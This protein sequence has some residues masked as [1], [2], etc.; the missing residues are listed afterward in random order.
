MG[1]T[2]R[3]LLDDV[4]AT[5]DQIVATLSVSSR[6]HVSSLTLRG[7]RMVLDGTD[8]GDGR[9]AFTLAHLSWRQQVEAP[10]AGGYRL[11]ATDE[12]GTNVPVCP[13][14]R[15]SRMTPV[16][17]LTYRAA[18][19]FEH[20]PDGQAYV[21]VSAPLC[22]DEQGRFH[23][24]RLA[25]EFTGD[26]AKS[27]SGEPEGVFLESWYGKTFS[28]NPAPLVEALRAVGVPGPYR[29]AVADRSVEHPA[30]VEA[31]IT[32]STDYWR[33]LGSSRV[34][35]FNTWLPSEFKKGRGQ[36]IVQTWHGT[37]L[38]SLGMDVPERIGS[39]RAAKNLRRGSQD[40]D[41]LV[42]Q[43]AYSTEILTR[44]YV[45]DGEVAET[46]Y[47]RND[48]LSAGRG[49]E[50][51]ARTRRLLGIP[52]SNALTLYAPTW[53]QSDKGSVGPLEVERLVELLPPNHVVAVRGHSVTLR[54][55]N[56]I[57]GRRI[58]DV[59]SYPEPAELMAAADVLVTDYSSI[60]FDFAAT[61]KP[62]VFYTPDYAKYMEEGRGGYF[63]LTAAAPGP[64]T[65]TPED[66]AS[67]LEHAVS[68]T[69]RPQRYHE[70][71]RT[72]T[73]NDDGGAADRLA[74][75]IAAALS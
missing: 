38:K 43:N 26:D 27:R 51:R 59:T 5:A 15:L 63:D 42:S 61:G 32:G 18:F 75:R 52:D 67:E 30:D 21:D 57:A 24:R 31:V 53:R 14:I 23:R 55:G 19:R 9:F 50:V 45:Y 10:P 28:D 37:P 1:G 47:P 11:W 40:W 65:Q 29:V 73:P 62:I 25:S 4:T 34:L 7:P 17:T 35:I 36:F 72:F 66:L 49:A 48:A 56:D 33:A 69:D 46:G 54:R 58:I 41:L 60:M 16:R 8:L 2:R 70:W 3:I 71:Q 6:L 22:D 44:A 64:L 74:Q 13:A 20:A 39:E 12:A 68:V